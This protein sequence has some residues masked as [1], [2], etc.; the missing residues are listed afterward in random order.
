[1]FSII[2]P[3]DSEPPLRRAHKKSRKG[4]RTCKERKLKVSIILISDIVRLIF[5]QDSVMK[6]TPSVETVSGASL[7]FEAAIGVNP[8]LRTAV[9]VAENQRKLFTIRLQCLGITVYD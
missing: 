3:P 5:T 6:S 7:R 4:C 8:H 1:M 9:L 2:I